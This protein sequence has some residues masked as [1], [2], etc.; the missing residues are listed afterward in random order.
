MNRVLKCIERI[1]QILTIV[2]GI[3]TTIETVKMYVY[4]KELKNRANAYLDDELEI[5]G[6]MR[7]AITVQSPT[8]E[9][10]Q[11][12]VVK[13]VGVTA[14]GAIISLLLNLINRDRY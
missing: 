8:L 7:G 14:I 13:L 1:I 10:K 4:K 5:E 9:E 3:W 2:V 12:R 11:K 6:N